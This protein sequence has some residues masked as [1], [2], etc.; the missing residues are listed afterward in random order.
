LSSAVNDKVI[1]QGIGH[2]PNVSAEEKMRNRRLN[3]AAIMLAVTCLLFGSAILA[4][5]LRANAADIEFET[6]FDVLRVQQLSAGIAASEQMTGQI[7]L[8]VVA[9]GVLTYDPTQEAFIPSGAFRMGCDVGNP[10]ENGCAAFLSQERELPLHTVYLDAYFID[11]YEVTNAHYKACVEA[12]ACK[13]P[14]DNRS[15]TRPSYYDN[16]HYADYPVINVTWHQATAYCTWAGKR[17]PTEAEWEKAS[18]GSSDTRM[19]PWGNSAP[20]CTKANYAGCIGDTNRVGA[21][22]NGASPYSVMDMAGNVWEWVNDWYDENY[23]SVSPFSNPQGLETG[24]FRVM[25][26]GDGRHND[27][28]IRS[29]DRGRRYPES[30]SNNGGFRC[31]RSL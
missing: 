14:G 17:L 31:A 20:D 3:T 10:A 27:D 13:A 9:V 25:R 21:Y 2:G 7:Y 16:P 28:R 8:P 5:S 26:G 24:W 23:Y 30:G 12:G 15:W 29:A 6:R 4:Q 22:P 19:Y 1:Q 18:R 11:K